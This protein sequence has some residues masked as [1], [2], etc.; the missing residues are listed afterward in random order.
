MIH[1]FL[2]ALLCLA[3][4][5]S[6]EP[7]E[8]VVGSVTKYDASMSSHTSQADMIVCLRSQSNKYIRLRY[9]P[10][11]F[12]FDAPKVRPE[13]L[14][15]N[16]MFSDGTLAWVFR[17]HSPRSPEEQTACTARTVQYKTGK[18]GKPVEVERFK[19]L[20]GHE[21]DNVPQPKSLPCFIIEAWSR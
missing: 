16:E 6:A 5:G 20:P 14:L 7:T 2:I 8:T 1:S 12:A 21:R 9:A 10:N 3:L 4:T 13:Q 17:I 19:S 18:R 11:G 15:P